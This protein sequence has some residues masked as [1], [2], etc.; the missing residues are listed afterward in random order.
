MRIDRNPTLNFFA[1]FSMLHFNDL[2]PT[3]A[4]IDLVSTHCNNL[5]VG[6]YSKINTKVEKVDH[7]LM[8]VFNESKVKTLYKR[9]AVLIQF[10]LI[11]G[12][13]R[14]ALRVGKQKI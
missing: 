1:L 6:G 9:Q 3:I 2:Q 12:V 4:G 14:K 5:T 10:I 8:N 7:L 11:R 13:F